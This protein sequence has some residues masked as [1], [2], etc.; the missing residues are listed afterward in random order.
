MDISHPL[1]AFT[2]AATARVL[3]VL[4]GT[5]RPLTGREIHR[6]AGQS[7]VASVWRILGR[8]SGQ[9][10]VTADHRGT[11]VYYTANR[12][13]LAWPAIEALV[14]IRAEL[15]A[16]L[17]ETIGGWAIQPLHSSLFGSA[18]RGDSDAES[19][20]DLL[21]VRPDSVGQN[22]EATW[23]DQVSRLRQAVHGW[24]GNDCQ[25]FQVDRARLLEH[26]D[27]QDPLVIAWLREGIK[28]TGQSLAE[29]AGGR[30]RFPVA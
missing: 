17:V 2:S 26:V 4:A 5:T 21:L 27:A 14:R 16:R 19:D 18:A 28:L 25:T 9:G 10:I 22:D 29:L 12:D 7:S 15:I 20:I 1:S 23:D 3:Q 8:L 24:T 30:L 13:H 6:I 11:A